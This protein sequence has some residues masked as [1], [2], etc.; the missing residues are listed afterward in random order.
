MVGNIED[1]DHEQLAQTL[2]IAVALSELSSVL[3][4]L[5]LD[6]AD[7]AYAEELEIQPCNGTAIVD[8]CNLMGR[9]LNA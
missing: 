5:C 9:R 4:Y 3:L 2:Y 1:V 7:E 6:E 8:Q